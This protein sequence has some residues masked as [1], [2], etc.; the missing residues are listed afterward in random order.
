MFSSNKITP[1]EPNNYARLNS[2]LR[3]L[4]AVPSTDTSS[5]L[6]PCGLDPIEK[7]LNL[8]ISA[9]IYIRDVPAGAIIY[10]TEP[11]YLACSYVNLVLFL[12]IW[13]LWLP[14]LVASKIA[15]KKFMNGNFFEGTKY[16]KRALTLNIICVLVGLL[17]YAAVVIGVLYTLNII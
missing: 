14:A 8:A 16:S 2:R 17:I 4:S 7:K 11:T 10:D 12:P 1:N 5:Y 6:T 9:P 15:K 13:F 3:E